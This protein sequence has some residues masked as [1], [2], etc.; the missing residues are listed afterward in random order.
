MAQHYKSSSNSSSPFE[1]INTKCSYCHSEFSNPYFLA[2]HIDDKHWNEMNVYPCRICEENHSS[3][4]QLIKHLTHQ[5]G[6][7]DMPYTCQLCSFRTSIY[8]DMIY[9]IDETHKST[10]Y[11]F[12]QYCLLAIELPLM[13][14][15][16]T[17]VLNGTLAYEHLSLHWKSIEQNRTNQCH[18]C[19]LHVS[20]IREHLQNDHAPINQ[21]NKQIYHHRKN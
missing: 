6:G 11:F 2:I 14:I 12:C 3:V 5:H 1:Q 17:K 16:N 15:N 21:V 9:H 19:L 20:S 13:T 4:S 18:R 7:L 10:R 8:G